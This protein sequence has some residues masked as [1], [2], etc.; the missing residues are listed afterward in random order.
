[1]L[2]HFLRIRNIILPLITIF[3]ELVLFHDQTAN[4]SGFQSKIMHQANALLVPTILYGLAAIMLYSTYDRYLMEIRLIFDY[5]TLSLRCTRGLSPLEEQT[6]ICEAINL[7]ACRET[8]VLEQREKAERDLKEMMRREKDRIHRERL[9]RTRAEEQRLS[10][11]QY[12]NTFVPQFVDFLRTIFG[13]QRMVVDEDNI[14]PSIRTGIEKQKDELRI[15][16]AKTMCCS[17]QKNFKDK[18]SILPNCLQG[19]SR[20]K[21]NLCDLKD[22]DLC[23]KLNCVTGS[24]NNN[25]LNNVGGSGAMQAKNRITAMCSGNTNNKQT[26][27]TNFNVFS[28]NNNSTAVKKEDANCISECQRQT[29]EQRAKSKKREMERERKEQEKCERELKARQIKCEKEERKKRQKAEEDVENQDGAVSIFNDLPRTDLV[30]NCEIKRVLDPDCQEVLRCKE[31]IVPP[32]ACALGDKGGGGGGMGKHSPAGPRQSP[33]GQPFGT[34]SNCNQ[35]GMAQRLQP[36]YHCA[37]SGI[38]TTNTCSTGSTGSFSTNSCSTAQQN[39]GRQMDGMNTSMSSVPSSNMAMC[40]LKEQTNKC[41]DSSCRMMNNNCAQKNTNHCDDTCSRMVTAN[42]CQSSG[43]RNS[44]T[45]P[46]FTTARSQPMN[47]TSVQAIPVQVTLTEPCNYPIGPALGASQM[48]DSLYR[49]I[50]ARPMTQYDGKNSGGSTANSFSNAGAATPLEAQNRRDICN[51]STFMGLRKQPGRFTDHLH[52]NEG[53]WRTP[54]SFVRHLDDN[55]PEN[56]RSA[57]SFLKYIKQVEANRFG[58]KEGNSCSNQ[59]CKNVNCSQRFD[60]RDDRSECD[61]RGR[62]LNRSASAGQ[63]KNLVGNQPN[64]G[65][66]FQPGT[67]NNMIRSTS[68]GPINKSCCSKCNNP[69]SS[70]NDAFHHGASSS[71][72]RSGSPPSANGACSE[73]EDTPLAKFNRSRSSGC[74]RNNNGNSCVDS[75]SSRYNGTRKCNAQCGSSNNACQLKGGSEETPERGNNLQATTISAQRE[76]PLNPSCSGNTDNN[77]LTETKREVF[78][79]VTNIDD[80]SGKVI[81]KECDTVI[82]EILHSSAVPGES[83]T[84]REVT[85]EKNIIQE[86][87]KTIREESHNTREEIINFEMHAGSEKSKASDAFES[88]KQRLDMMRRMGSNTNCDRHVSEERHIYGRL[89]GSPDMTEVQSEAEV[90]SRVDHHHLGATGLKGGSLDKRGQSEMSIRSNSEEELKHSPTFLRAQSAESVNHNERYY[91]KGDFCREFTAHL[92]NSHYGE[93]INELKSKLVHLKSPE[94]M[95]KVLEQIVLLQT[96]ALVSFVPREGKKYPRDIVRFDPDLSYSA[97]MKELKSVMKTNGNQVIVS[98]AIKDIDAINAEIE[99]DMRRMMGVRKYQE[100]DDEEQGKGYPNH[101]AFAHLIRELREKIRDYEEGALSSRSD[102]EVET[103]EQR[104]Q[105]IEVL[106]D[107]LDKR[108]RMLGMPAQMMT[109][110]SVFIKNLFRSLLQINSELYFR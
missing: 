104:R 73:C 64:Y 50:N 103:Q 74:N 36:M 69:H 94:E 75:G 23:G 18:K 109:E 61:I 10:R 99:K 107:E 54:G 9:E 87:N 96:E 108:K 90:R 106:R 39:R 79:T 110:E 3:C 101:Y 21:I 4:M 38:T 59:S 95:H 77:R 46:A 53:N 78:K 22:K 51:D 55:Q 2:V 97:L 41:D 44:S 6:Y 85:V 48:E 84:L 37:N 57:G 81:R 89:K 92:E 12:E 7:H 19:I 31:V 43:Q 102:E 17:I 98:K 83:K 16:A 58:R 30:M 42:Q 62:R 52:Q 91:G 65:S 28:P 40:G 105:R 11:V 66:A 15:C 26:N 86:A 1:M 93:L 20:A 45:G 100:Q 27:Q 33:V 29:D 88:R 56:W 76:D 70:L 60:R 5:L 25:S 80:P 63:S 32:P 8:M 49:G 72:S 35:K 34:V 24:S 82:E 13:L 47:K 68:L 14:P 67:T 71:R